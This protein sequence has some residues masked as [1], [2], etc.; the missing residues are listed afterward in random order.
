LLEGLRH[1][2]KKTKVNI[3]CARWEG[4][5]ERGGKYYYNMIVRNGC[6]KEGRKDVSTGY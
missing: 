4:G 6:V 1:L 3:R 5:E 2:T